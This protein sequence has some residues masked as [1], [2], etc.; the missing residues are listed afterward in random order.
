MVQP[1]PWK[2]KLEMVIGMQIEILNGI[3]KLPFYGS[4]QIFNR[5]ETQH[6]SFMIFFRISICIPITISNLIFHGMGCSRPE[7]KGSTETK[8]IWLFLKP[9]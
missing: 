4:F 3:M 6:S 5:K 2:M 9:I 8:Q 7:R 1:V